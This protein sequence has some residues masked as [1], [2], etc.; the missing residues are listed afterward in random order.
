MT[1]T[2]S[3]K[4]ARRTSTPLVVARTSDAASVMS[5]LTAE[6]T[7]A[8]I[9]QWDAAQGFSARTDAG[10][11]ALNDLCGADP[12]VLNP[13][14]AMH[15]LRNVAPST[16]IF[17]LNGHRVW[18]D[19][20]TAQAIWNLRDVFKSNGRMLVLLVT[21]EAKAPRELDSD[22]IVIDDPLPDDDQLAEIIN[23][24]HEN[25]DLEKPEDDTLHRAID[26]LKGISAF[27][28]E[29]ITAMCLTKNGLDLNELWERKRQSV[30]QTPGATVFRQ[31]IMFSD[32]G[33]HDGLKRDLLREVKSK[34]PVKVVVIFDEFEKSM[35]GAT[36]D[37]S[38]VSQDASKVVLTYMQDNDVRGTILF[39]HPG[40][41]KT[42]VAKAMG[43]EAD[44]IVIMADMGAMKGSLVGESEAKIRQFFTMVQSIAGDGGAFFVATCNSTAALTTE[45][46]RRFKT[47]FYFV[48][49]PD[50]QEKDAVWKIHMDK[51]GIKAQ[52]KP[53][54]T[55]WTGAEIESCCEKA[56]N[57]SIALV[58]AATSIVSVA[59][60]QPEL[61]R[62]RRGEAHGRLLSSSTGKTY[63]YDS[64]VDEVT[65]IAVPVS[66]PAPKGSRKVT[67]N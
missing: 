30:E 16:I 66:G 28:A 5:T 39:G 46:R 20:S 53:D 37:T 13:A 45:M 51:R 63:E 52:Q 58:D 61:I 19:I 54:D 67:V 43:A 18:Q 35:A 3:F 38:G 26:A 29:Q 59:Q 47:G 1:I 10:V 48:D 56:D 27:V 23:A 9:M 22:V 41:G 15:Q 24:Q 64:G 62:E 57:Y 60:A 44:C 36:G 55:N 14:D 17:V 2:N 8:P 49:L 7:D 40:A 32:I 42:L 21:P 31:R 4:T 12:G 11:V 33:G 25:A 65:V 6:Y 34:R 50:R